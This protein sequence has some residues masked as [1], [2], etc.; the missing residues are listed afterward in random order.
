MIEGYLDNRHA[1]ISEF[2]R[3]LDL[4]NTR[5]T[6]RSAN[7]LGA[8]ANSSLVTTVGPDMEISLVTLRNLLAK[9]SGHSQ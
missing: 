6:F 9:R 8:L 3:K 4:E 1:K 5:K 2:R 7:G